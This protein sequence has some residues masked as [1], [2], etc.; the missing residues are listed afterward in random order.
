MPSR[1]FFE[2]GGTP[3]PS[4]FASV[5]QTFDGWCYSLQGCGCLPPEARIT[6]G[7]WALPLNTCCPCLLIL[8]QWLCKRCTP[9]IHTDEQ[10][11]YSISELKA[12]ASLVG[13]RG[14][15]FEYSD[16]LIQCRNLHNAIQW[17]EMSRSTSSQEK[18]NLS[19][20][21]Y[22]LALELTMLCVGV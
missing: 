10:A 21:K 13:L 12:W 17:P 19:N 20:Q 22:E 2:I 16:E 7:Q 14:L 18:I 5:S 9:I 8:Y 1:L 6:D 4:A 11:V 15:H 3:N